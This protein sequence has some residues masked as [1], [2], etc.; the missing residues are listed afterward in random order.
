MYRAPSSS[1][2]ESKGERSDIIDRSNLTPHSPRRRIAESLLTRV[3]AMTRPTFAEPAYPA[4]FGVLA[5]WLGP[6][7]VHY[8][9]RIRGDR[10][11][12]L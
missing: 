4:H 5:D 10:I 7:N 2:T 6:A 3:R 12:G 9:N 8:T 11:N 1:E